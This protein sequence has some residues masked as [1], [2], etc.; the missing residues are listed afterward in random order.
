MRYTIFYM[1]YMI[2]IPETSMENW[3]PG[4]QYMGRK[5]EQR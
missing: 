2:R 5:N 4:Q 1:I 3:L